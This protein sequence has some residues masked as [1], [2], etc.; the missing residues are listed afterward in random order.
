MYEGTS[1][2]ELLAQAR[3]TPAESVAKALRATAIERNAGLTRSIARRYAG[4]GVETEDLVQVAALALVLAAGRFDPQRGSAFSAYARITIA[5]ELKRHLR[6]HA[7]AV[8]P[9]RALHDAHFEM[10]QVA[11][12]LT[13]SLGAMPTRC[14]IAVALNTTVDQVRKTQ[15]VASSFNAASLDALLVERPDRSPGGELNVG[16]VGSVDALVT[17]IALQDGVRSLRP[18]DQLILRLRFEE[19]LTQRQIG[20]RVGLSQMQVSRRLAAIV[21]LLRASLT[22]DDGHQLSAAG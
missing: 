4:R 15:E 11:Q 10:A 22:G 18:R 16:S 5:G 2:E 6:D 20:R 17:R 21:Q 1:T 14:D 3:R 8:R 13:Q 19:D 7:W 12:D 9:P